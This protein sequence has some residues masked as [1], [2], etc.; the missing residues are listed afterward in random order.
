MRILDSVVV[1][2]RESS[3]RIKDDVLNT[4]NLIMPSTSDIQ[5]FEDALDKSGKFVSF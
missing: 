2:M 5:R 3:L 4:I 1:R